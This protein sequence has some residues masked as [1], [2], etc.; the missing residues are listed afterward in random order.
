MCGSLLGHGAFFDEALPLINSMPIE[1]DTSLWRALLSACKIYSNNKLVESVFAKLT[2]LDPMVEG[3]YVLLSS[4]YASASLWWEI[5]WVRELI[6]EK[7]L[8]ERHRGISWIVIKNEVAYFAAGYRSHV[9]SD[10]IYEVLRSMFFSIKEAGYVPDFQ[11]LL[12]EEN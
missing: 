11:A 2:E 5:R 8:R 10:V 3:N 4:I 12:N 7:I 1:A 6:K 9:K